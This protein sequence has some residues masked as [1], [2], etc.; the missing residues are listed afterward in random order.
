[1]KLYFIKLKFDRLMRVLSQASYSGSALGRRL[2]GTALAAAPELAYSAAEV[3][4]PLIV[5]SVLADASIPF[6]FDTLSGALPCATALEEILM[7]T[8]V[9][10]VIHTGQKISQASHKYINCEKWH[11]NGIGHFVKVLSWWDKEKRQ[12]EIFTLDIDASDGLTESCAAEINHSLAKLLN[13]TV[14]LSGSCTDSGGGGV[15][16]CLAECLKKLGVTTQVYL[17]ANC[18]LHAV[19]RTLANPAK[20]VFGDGGL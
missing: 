8:A 1:M 14:H 5:A 4:F 2:I 17:V 9:D 19:Q 11:S 12:V 15:L 13:V 10:C 7:A 16:E 6:D 18:T 20:A 3:I